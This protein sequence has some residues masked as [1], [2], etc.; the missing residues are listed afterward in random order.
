MARGPTWLVLEVNRWCGPIAPHEER[1]LGIE[2]D[3]P[4]GGVQL[5]SV[6]MLRCELGPVIC[7]FLSQVRAVGLT[8]QQGILGVA[9]GRVGP[10]V[11]APELRESPSV[12]DEIAHTRLLVM[13]H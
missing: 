5:W 9:E 3:A 2:V 11:V 6:R 8:E 1:G 12:V 10:R 7:L 13:L 4:I